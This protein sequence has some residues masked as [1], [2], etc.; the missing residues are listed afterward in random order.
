MHCVEPRSWVEQLLLE[1]VAQDRRETLTG[2]SRQLTRSDIELA[3]EPQAGIVARL[4]EHCHNVASMQVAKHGATLIILLFQVLSVDPNA[5][6]GTC[7]DP[8]FELLKVG[9]VFAL[10]RKLLDGVAT[11]AGRGIPEEDEGRLRDARVF[12]VVVHQRITGEPTP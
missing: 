6:C 1:L 10:L 2:R 9:P 5:V 7:P 3:L 12:A 4:V 11:L 8:D